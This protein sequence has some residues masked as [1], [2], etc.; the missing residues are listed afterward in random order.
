MK[1]LWH[2]KFDLEWLRKEVTSLECPTETLT[3]YLYNCFSDAVDFADSFKCNGQ[4]ASF[5]AITGTF[6]PWKKTIGLELQ[7]QSFSPRDR[8][9]EAHSLTLHDRDNL[10]T[11]SV[12]GEFYAI[13]NNS[14]PTFEELENWAFGTMFARHAVGFLGGLRAS[15]LSFSH[16]YHRCNVDL[17]LVSSFSMVPLFG[18]CFNGHA[19]TIITEI[20]CKK[21][22]PIKRSPWSLVSCPDL[23][24][25]GRATANVRLSGCAHSAGCHYHQRHRGLRSGRTICPAETPL[26]TQRSREG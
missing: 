17:P 22:C 19:L 7:V 12:P 23:S 18:F 4:D 11:R 14:L 26:R 20:S 10:Q 16:R 25:R 3:L 8:A 9:G 6:F 15:F 21:C 24:E 5:A 2:Q 1:D 13:P